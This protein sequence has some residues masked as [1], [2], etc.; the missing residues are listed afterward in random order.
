MVNNSYLFFVLNH[1]TF[2][3]SGMFLVKQIVGIDSKLSTYYRNCGEM[4]V[5]DPSLK[6]AEPCKKGAQVNITKE[7]D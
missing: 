5:K 1:V 7:R 2:Y 3:Y 4:S 6:S